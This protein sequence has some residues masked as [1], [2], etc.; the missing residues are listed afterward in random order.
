MKIRFNT[1][2][3][4][5]SSAHTLILRDNNAWVSDADIE[6]HIAAAKDACKTIPDN[7][8]P[9]DSFFGSDDYGRGY[10]MLLEWHEKFSYLV[11]SFKYEREEFNAI[12]EALK[13]RIP[14]TKGIVVLD[15]YTDYEEEEEENTRTPFYSDSYDDFAC[16]GS[17]DHQSYDTGK[18]ALI[19]IRKDPMYANMSLAEIFYNMI[20]CNKFVII[21]DSDETDT[22]MNLYEKGF[23][24]ST[25]FKYVLYDNWKW[26]KETNESTTD[27]IFMNFEDYMHRHDG[28]DEE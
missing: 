24:K 26:D 12:I 18:E 5:S 19:A 4:N 10:S 17:I 6:E 15:Q 1:F 20:F 27:P 11:A 21:T 3:T 28:E 22:F 7:Y 16:M 14:N 25:D 9:T 13:M 23:F 2:E 8:I